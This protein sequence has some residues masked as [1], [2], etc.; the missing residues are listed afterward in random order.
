ME[1]NAVEQRIVGVLVEK[2]FTT[3]KGYPLTVNALHT[4]CNQQ[5][6]RDPVLNLGE[7][8]VLEALDSLRGKGMATVTIRESG[9]A[10]RWSHNVETALGLSPKELAVMTELFLRGPQTE[11]ELRARASRMTPLES[12]GEVTEILQGLAGR[13]QPLVVRME[14]ERGRRGVRYRH[15]LYPEGEE[16]T[17]IAA[18]PAGPDAAMAGELLGRVERLEGDVAALKEEVARLRGDQSGGFQGEGTDSGV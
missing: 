5:S 14:K 1:L 16:P 4:G 8:Q 2:A 13:E 12:I 17:A 15:T 10:E 9:R 18:A 7:D 3:P 6:N 11:G